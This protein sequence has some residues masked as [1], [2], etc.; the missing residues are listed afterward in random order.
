MSLMAT[1]IIMTTNMKVTITRKMLTITA[2][3]MV[4]MIISTMTMK[5]S[6]TRN[7]TIMEMKI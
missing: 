3:S 4:M 2:I 1:S 6:N 7:V 5:K